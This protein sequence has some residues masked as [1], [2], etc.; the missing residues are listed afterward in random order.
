MRAIT[1]LAAVL[2]GCGGPDEGGDPVVASAYDQR[3]HWSDLRQVIPVETGPEDSAAMAAAYVNNWLQQ[4]VVLHKAEENIAEADKDFGAKLL[5][6]RNSLLLFAYEQEL[7]NQKLDTNVTTEQME[8]YLAA[9]KVDF[10]LKDDI[11]RLRW[12]KATIGDERTKRSLQK[13]FERGGPDDRRQIELWTA[14]NG[15]MIDDR[16]GTWT[17]WTEFRTELP[18]AF[19][20]RE[21]LFSKDDREVLQHEDDAV[22]I[23]VLEH[24]QKGDP[25]PLSVVERDV[26]AILLNQRKLQLLERM[27]QDLYREALDRQDIRIH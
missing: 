8:E 5:D 22:F 14:Q 10:E 20:D 19:E 24:R 11:A 6:Y 25:S 13:A 9:N 17:S 21:D 18:A 2:M 16:S 3:L 1:M 4:Q 26:R 7:V 15:V 27:R 23:E 12:F